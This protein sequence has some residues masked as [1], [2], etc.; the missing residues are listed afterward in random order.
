MAGGMWGVWEGVLST[1]TAMVRATSKTG[2]A[3]HMTY[4]V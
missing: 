4:L 1:C 3:G 2:V